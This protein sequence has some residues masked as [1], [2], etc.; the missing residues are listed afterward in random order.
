MGNVFYD[1]LNKSDKDL[2]NY[3][4]KC[5]KLCRKNNFFKSKRLCSIILRF[6]E[7]TNRT[8]DKKDSDYDDCILFNYWIYDG[9]SRKFNY[10]YNIKVYHEFAEIQRV[11]NELIQD[12]SQITY[13]DKCKPDNSIVNQ[14]DWKQRKELYDY[15][16]NY[17]LI[18]KQ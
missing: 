16:V 8:S 14:Q 2:D 11:W 15:C 13:F 6:L 4:D 3:T 9:L 1:K 12:A 18:Q 17:E 5:N 7:G 10:N